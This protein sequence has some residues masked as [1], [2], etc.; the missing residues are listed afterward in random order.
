MIIIDEPELHFT[1]SITESLMDAVE[2]ERPDCLF[3]YLTRRFR[4]CSYP[5]KFYQDLAEKLRE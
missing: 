2:A 5:C 1:Q 4:F 3:I